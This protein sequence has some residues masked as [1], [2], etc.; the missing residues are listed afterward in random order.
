MNSLC[1]DAIQTYCHTFTMT[2]R[3][4]TTSKHTLTTAAQM[5]PLPGWN[6][7]NITVNV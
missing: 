6:I 5:S 7:A 1:S 3:T 2:G 4:Q